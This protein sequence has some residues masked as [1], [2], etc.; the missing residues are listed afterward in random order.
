MHLGE[1][2]GRNWAIEDVHN[3]GPDYDRTLMAW[4]HNIEAAWDD[5]PAY[6]EHFRRTW[7]YYLQAAAASFRTR[8]LQLW[9]VVFTK[10][11]QYSDTY[12]AVR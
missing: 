2:A 3:F 11:G 7:R 10:V 5:L 1:G 6:D 4:L 9:Q 12:Q 8:H